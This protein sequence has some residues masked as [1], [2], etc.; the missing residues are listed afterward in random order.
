MD[1]LL[2]RGVRYLLTLPA[3]RQPVQTLRRLGVPLTIA[4][5]RWMLG[6]KRRLVLLRDPGR[7]FPKPARIAE[8]SHTGA[9]VSS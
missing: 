7:L 3:F 4:R 1:A 5:T 2:R 8:I 6:A 9:P